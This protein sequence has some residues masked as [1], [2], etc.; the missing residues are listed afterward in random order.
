M[1]PR[2]ALCLVLLSPLSSAFAQVD[3]TPSSIG[4]ANSEGSPNYQPEDARYYPGIKLQMIA[5]NDDGVGG[6]AIADQYDC[7]ILSSCGPSRNGIAYTHYRV[8]LVGQ[9]GT[10]TEFISGTCDGD[11]NVQTCYDHPLRIQLRVKTGKNTINMIGADSGKPHIVRAGV[12]IRYRIP[13]PYDVYWVTG[14]GG[15]NRFP[16]GTWTPEAT[17]MPSGECN[18]EPVDPNFTV[19]VTDDLNRPAVNWLWRGTVCDY[20]IYSPDGGGT[21][22]DGGG[23]IIGGLSCNLPAGQATTCNF[24]APYGEDVRL[25]ASSDTQAPVFKQLN[26]VCGYSEPDTVC[27]FEADEDAE[28]VLEFTDV[29]NKPRFNAS[30]GANGPASRSADKGE[31]NVSVQQLQFTVNDSPAMTSMTISAAGT[32]APQSDITAA[33]VFIDMNGNGRVDD[34]DFQLGTGTFD[35]NGVAVVTFDEP[36]QQNTSFKLV[37]GVDFNTEIQA[38]V[39]LPFAPW[40]LLLVAALPVVLLRRRRGLAV[41]VLVCAIAAS[42]AC[43]SGGGG[44]NNDTD[45]DQQGDGGGDNGPQGDDDYVPPAGAKTY[46]FSVTEATAQE[47]YTTVT[48]AAVL[49]LP[50]S[51]ATISVAP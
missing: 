36:Y 23:N 39:G 37:V 5:Y 50:L 12:D 35:G 4:F 9:T 20:R 22:A 26:S 8:T 10:N 45:D 46:V 40:S 31:A 7:N 17:A 41:C 43:G 24:S 6:L 13:G 16:Q 25:I 28:I 38:G 11:T 33:K 3:P 1:L 30:A 32:G 49:G 34:A 44:G 2:F 21:V 47:S 19:T 18:P 42:M 51:G 29:T 14:S 27:A 48:P 15:A